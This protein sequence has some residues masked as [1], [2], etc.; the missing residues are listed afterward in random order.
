MKIMVDGTRLTTLI[1]VVLLSS[2][3]CESTASFSTPKNT[4]SWSTWSQWDCTC[5]GNTIDQPVY[6]VR[7][8]CCPVT[9]A[10][11]S[12][13]ETA[14]KIMSNG[15][16]FLDKGMCMH[17]CKNAYIYNSN[18]CSSAVPTNDQNSLSNVPASCLHV[19]LGNTVSFFSF[20]SISHIK[21]ML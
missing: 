11:A 8:Q 9:F 6:R 17:D 5:C 4:C 12:L 3:I 19:C 2:F 21:V 13:R 20:P 15:T 14:E 1:L 16:D 10:C 7:T 18:K